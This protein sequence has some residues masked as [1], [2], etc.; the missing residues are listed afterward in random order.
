MKD[1]IRVSSQA[2]VKR[3]CLA[4]ER[5]IDDCVNHVKTPRNYENP[6]GKGD[7]R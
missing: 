2:K 1:E 4:S 3:V 6:R 7:E 5:T